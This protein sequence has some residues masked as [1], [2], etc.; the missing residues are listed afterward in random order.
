MATADAGIRVDC[1]RCGETVLH[2]AMIPVLG[3]EGAGIAYVCCDCA[4][5]DIPP[6]EL[7]ASA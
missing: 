4:R 7:P 1:P 6:P 5:R 2:K 3:P